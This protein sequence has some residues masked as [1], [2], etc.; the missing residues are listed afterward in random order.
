[1]GKK[2]LGADEAGKEAVEG[3]WAGKLGSMIQ[4]MAGSG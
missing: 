4:Q 1:M 3:A 2:E